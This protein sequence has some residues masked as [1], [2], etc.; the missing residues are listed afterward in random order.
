V[1]G[2]LGAHTRERKLPGRT[3][4]SLLEHWQSRLQPGELEAI[5]ATVVNAI[6]SPLAMEDRNRE[7]VDWTLEH[8]LERRSAV[9]QRQVVTE[10]LKHDLGSVTPEDVYKELGSRKDLIRRRVDG[11]DMVSTQEVLSEE[12]RIEA[13]AKKGKGRFRPLSSEAAKTH[14]PLESRAVARGG[15]QPRS[16]AEGGYRAHSLGLE[17]RN[18]SINTSPARP[19]IVTLSPSQQ[20]AIRHVWNSRDRLILIRGAAGTGKTTLTKTALAGVDVPW[21]ILAP[22][23]E[24]SRG[25]LR[26]DGFEHADT[27]AKFLTD[28]EMQERVRGGLIWLDEASLAGAR[29][30]SKLAQLA[31]SLNARIVLSGDRRQHKSVARGDVLALLQDKV[32]LP[33]AEVS[34]IKRQS[35]EYK[36][37][38]AALAKGD[39]GTGF[40]KLDQ[41]GWVKEA[42][43]EQLAEDYLAAV[44]GGKS[45]LTICPTHSEGR[46]VSAA[47]REKLR[48]GGLLAGEEKRFGTL[49]NANLTKAEQGDPE[50]LKAYAGS[51]AVY[52]RHG[53]RARAGSRVEITEENAAD[54]AKEAGR[55]VVY[56]PQELALAAGDTVRV[57]ANSK[58]IT[59]KH[60]LNNGAIY[61]VDGFTPAGNI[62][63]NNGWVVSKEAPHL[64]H[65]YV[66]TSHA[67]QGRTVDVALVAMGNESLPAMGSEQLYVSASRARQQTHLYVQD[68]DAVREAI[69]REDHR[70]LASEF[71]RKPR[72]GIRARLKNHIAWLRGIVQV[73]R[74]RTHEQREMEVT[75]DR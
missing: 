12:M 8:L 28:R 30:V 75:R 70:V 63:M 5:N 71:V 42:G 41:L 9:P 17:D 23:A 58:D 56:K 59:G 24:A 48:E 10:A 67:A 73:S 69:Q 47:I 26:R 31:D 54:L 66:V 39:V 55:F 38:V 65:G 53:S 22:S 45:V 57:T 21:V 68:G 18:A 11:V 2:R 72:R 29:D 7:A 62:K 37:A 43:H 74:E 35:G 61:Q 32:G 36:S 25:V 51:Q 19:D 16:G 40:S 52:V 4:E 15:H 1:K 13:F 20:A 33:V 34:E 50:T 44:R 46:K 6:C 14:G 64:T 27:L 3:W 49:E 60:R